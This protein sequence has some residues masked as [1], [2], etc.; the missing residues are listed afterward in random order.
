MKN[1]IGLSRSAPIIASDAF[2]RGLDRRVPTI[3]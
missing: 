1:P 3:C 2:L